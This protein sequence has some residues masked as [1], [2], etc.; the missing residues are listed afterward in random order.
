MLCG[1]EKRRLYAEKRV[2]CFTEQ[3]HDSNPILTQIS[4]AMTEEGECQAEMEAAILRGDQGESEL[5]RK[6]MKEA[7]LKKEHGNE[8]LMKCS[9]RY[10]KRM[11]SIREEAESCNGTWAA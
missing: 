2:E 5:W 6:R 8:M 11:K 3:L 1:D 7:S 10:A 4:D 9:A